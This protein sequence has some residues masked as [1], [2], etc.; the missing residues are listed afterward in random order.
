M[1]IGITISRRRTLSGGA[2]TA[3]LLLA[4]CGATGGAG[5]GPAPAVK[6]PVKLTYLLHNATKREVD[7]R[8]VP[9][10]KEKNPH[11]DVEFSMIPDAELTAKITFFF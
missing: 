11:I 5:D 1:S 2:V 3:P 4:A 6:Q 8:H 7:E 10:Y 9:E